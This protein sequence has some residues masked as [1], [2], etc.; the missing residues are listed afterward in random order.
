MLY[1]DL[2]KL[3]LEQQDSITRALKK[4]MLSTQVAPFVVPALQSSGIMQVLK[5]LQA[6]LDATDISDLAQRFRQEY[7]EG[8]LFDPALVP[9]PTASELREFVDLYLSPNGRADTWTLRQRLVAYS[10]AAVFKDCSIM[11]KTPLQPG[12]NGTYGI[13]PGSTEIKIIDLDLKPMQSLRKWYDHDEEVWRHWMATHPEEKESRH[14]MSHAPAMV[15]FSALDVASTNAVFM[16]T[17]DTST[18]GTPEHDGP[19]ASTQSLLN[20]V[21]A[22]SHTQAQ[23]GSFSSATDPSTFNLED[24]LATTLTAAAPRERKGSFRAFHRMETVTELPA[25]ERFALDSSPKHDLVPSSEAVL[26]E[27][28]V[29]QTAYDRER[30]S[31]APS[32]SPHTD[33]TDTPSIAALTIPQLRTPSPNSSDHHEMATV[34]SAVQSDGTTHVS[35]KDLQRSNSVEVNPAADGW[36]DEMQAL[37]ST[38]FHTPLSAITELNQS[39]TSW[40]NAQ[41]SSDE[42]SDRPANDGHDIPPLG[43]AFST[44]RASTSGDLLIPDF[45]KSSEVLERVRSVES[46]A[47]TFGTGA[48]TPDYRPRTASTL[49]TNVHF[50]EGDLG[51][52]DDPT[53]T[54]L[55]TGEQSSPPAN[56]PSATIAHHYSLGP[57]MTVST[58]PANQR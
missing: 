26:G 53:I 7:P 49:Y 4:G 28:N 25:S 44:A 37:E 45:E 35:S 15:T 29:D 50:S 10:L 12:P 1:C 2:T 54:S 22:L 30:S 18:E 5:T 55:T 34:G 8:E 38:P 46:D 43:P 58:D 23:D 32:P 48:K 40:D 3:S 51:A 16:P 33:T 47:G 36:T 21:P 20:E 39:T 9:E 11:L 52:Q 42:P 17:R 31:F 19:D 14:S 56:I 24:P 27:L 13:E 6:S 41:E 57:P